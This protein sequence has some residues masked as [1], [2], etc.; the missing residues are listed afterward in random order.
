MRMYLSDDASALEQQKFISYE[1]EVFWTL[2]IR[3][4]LLESNLW[5]GFWSFFIP[6]VKS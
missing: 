1:L 2:A 4:D 3:Q 5:M 6:S